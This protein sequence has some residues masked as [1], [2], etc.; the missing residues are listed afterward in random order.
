[1]DRSE[2]TCGVA[3]TATVPELALDMSENEATGPWCLQPLVRCLHCP[4][5]SGKFDFL[6]DGFTSCL[7]IQRHA[8]LDS[9]CMFLRQF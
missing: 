5:S 3:D 1:M 8:W 6:G 4:R 9:G 7:C 2:D